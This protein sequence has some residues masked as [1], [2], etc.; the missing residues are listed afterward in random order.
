VVKILGQ[1]SQLNSP[2]NFSKNLFGVESEW[3][4]G[5]ASTCLEVEREVQMACH[6]PPPLPFMKQIPTLFLLL[7][8]MLR[9]YDWEKYTINIFKSRLAQYRQFKN[10]K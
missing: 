2:Q 5:F 8:Y 7:S 9:I 4:K 6:P 3:K 10:G 1:P